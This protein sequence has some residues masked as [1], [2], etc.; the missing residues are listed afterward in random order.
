MADRPVP[1]YTLNLSHIECA[2]LLRRLRADKQAMQDD[3]T[4]LRERINSGHNGDLVQAH[5]MIDAEVDIADG[6]IRKLW[7]TCPPKT[8]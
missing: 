5:R 1:P 6:I 4:A 7:L 2:W 3:L 8:T